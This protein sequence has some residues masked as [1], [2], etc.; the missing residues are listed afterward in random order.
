MLTLRLWHV[1][2]LQNDFPMLCWLLL[3]NMHMHGQVL[4]FHQN[5][6]APHSMLLKTVT[7]LIQPDQLSCY[8]ELATSL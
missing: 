6:Y 3:H 5:R 1:S 7:L 2:R 4:R 8:D